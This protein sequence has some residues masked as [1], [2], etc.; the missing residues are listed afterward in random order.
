MLNVITPA[1]Y[2]S[3]KTKDI[4]LRKKGMGAEDTEVTVL[5]SFILLILV[6]D[7]IPD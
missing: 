5:T 6:K 1:D 2:I 7:Q 4:S 3:F